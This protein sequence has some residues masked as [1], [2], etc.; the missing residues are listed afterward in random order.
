[1]RDNSAAAKR[2]EMINPVTQILMTKRVELNLELQRYEYKWRRGEISFNEYNTK[3]KRLLREY[4]SAGNKINNKDIN[5]DSEPKG[6]LG[7]LFKLVRK[8]S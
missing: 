2:K 5:K 8:L 7:M 6:V 4:H 3:T 1:M